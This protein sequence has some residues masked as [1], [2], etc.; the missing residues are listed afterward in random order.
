MDGIRRTWVEINIDNAMHNIK[1]IRSFTGA[2]IIAVIKA[3]AYGHGVVEIAKAHQRIGVDY[4]AVACLQEA[5]ELRDAGIKERILILGVTPEQGLPIAAEYN[6]TQTVFSPEYAKLVSRVMQGA[7]KKI[8]VHFKVDTGM[9]RLGFH[10]NCGDIEKTAA[11]I[12]KAVNYP[13]IEAEGM[14]MHF[15]DAENP[16]K[17]FTDKQMDL[18]FS[19]AGTLKNKG[20]EFEILHC[21]NSAAVINYKRAHLSYVRPGLLLYGLYPDG[22]RINGLNLKPVMAF[23]STISEIRTV[24]EGESI[25]YGRTFVAEKDMRVAIVPAGYADGVT[26]GLTGFAEFLIRGKRARVLGRIC[27]DMCVLDL[28]GIDEACVGDCVTM[29]GSDCGN[30][31]SVDEWANHLNTINY[32][33]CCLITKR[34]PRVYIEHEN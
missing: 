4:F 20:I 28:S 22:K 1:E 13:G 7:E 11:D 26:R 3:D 30:E 25:S 15:A 32:E 16:D 21:A 14:Y 12:C 24:R 17:T 6:L 34:V 23:K 19:L 33:I 5:I 2:E 9:G 29:F 8:C 18:F 10:A 27:M 31:V